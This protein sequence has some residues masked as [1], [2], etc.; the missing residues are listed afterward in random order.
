MTECAQT[1]FHFATEP[2]R[3]IVAGFDGGT[4]TTEAGGLLL[5]NTEQKTGIPRQF[6]GCF[7]A[8]RMW[9]GNSGAGSE[10][11]AKPGLAKAR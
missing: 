2:R 8:R 10:T 7:R 3:E 6:A 4:I 9:K 1:S 11:A 5:H